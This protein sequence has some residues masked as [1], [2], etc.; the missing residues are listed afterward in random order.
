M[1]TEMHCHTSEKSACSHVRA[2]DLVARAHKLGLQAV[3]LTD[4]HYQWSDEDLERVKQEACVP[5]YF[6][7]LSGQEFKTRDFGDVLVY[8]LRETLAGGSLSLSELRAR[9]PDA[10]LV[11]AHPYRHGAAP[12][13]EQLLNPAWQGIEIF[14]SNY[15]VSDSAR[16]VADWHRYRF[17]ALAGTDTHGLTYTGTYPTQFDHHIRSIED[18]VDQL[19]R[20]SCRPYFKETPRTGATDTVVTELTIGYKAS[21]LRKQVIVKSYEDVQLWKDG[22]RT[23]EI[24]RQLREAGFDRGPFVI[25]KPLGKDR[26]SLALV[27]ERAPGAS[28][29][30]TIVDSDV[31]AARAH[32][33]RCAGWLAK[34]HNLNVHISPDDEFLAIEQE[35][36]DHY[37]E[38][39]RERDHPHTKRVEQVRDAVWAWERR[40]VE[41]TPGELVQG[42]GD[43]H[44]KNL[45][46]GTHEP[47]GEPYT[48]AIDFDSSYV[49]PAAFDVG[50]FVSQYRNMFFDRLDILS[51]VPVELFVGEYLAQTG[52]ASPEFDFQLDVYRARTNLS[53]LAYLAKV[54]MGGSENFWSLLVD[55]ERRVAGA[56]HHAHRLRA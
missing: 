29:F 45:F 26:S 10:A 34:L 17:T 50:S 41:A 31:D 12:T 6:V 28:L 9:Y 16:A 39:I 20:G 51:G 53:I 42:H 38:A 47:S 44:P 56:S 54:G 33:R 1:L 52:K 13:E 36:L 35:R 2:V 14:S 27:E 55:A 18:L 30:D 22:E 25:P 21:P 40:V 32:L 24:V 49:L 5:E 8:G 43:F 7:V 19:K 48:A 23:Q 37:V 15:T 11:W 46:I 4:H 3:V